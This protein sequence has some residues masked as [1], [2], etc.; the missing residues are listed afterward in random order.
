MTHGDHSCMDVD[1]ADVLLV[2]HVILPLFFTVHIEICKFVCVA[3]YK[4]A[5]GLRLLFVVEK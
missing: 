5:Y 1:A 2:V 3:S 4:P